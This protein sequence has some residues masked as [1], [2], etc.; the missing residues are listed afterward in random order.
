[1]IKAFLIDLDGTLVDTKLA[2]VAAYKEALHMLGF[3]SGE[4]ALE[5]WAGILPW[6]QMLSK[7]LPN[8]EITTL[9]KIA[10]LKRDL[11]SKYFHMVHV[12]EALVELIKYSK[13]KT[14]MAIVTS[15]SQ[16]SAIPLLSHLDLLNYFDEII[17]SEDCNLRK[18]HPEPYILAATRLNVSPDECL[19]FEDSDIGMKS[20]QA[21]GAKALRVNQNF[22]FNEFE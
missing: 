4:E 1:M 18:P 17:T 7:V 15:A 9:H 14:L 20:A 13:E 16:S 19:V 21:F 12:N 11:Y 10:L 2:N 5:K 8:A 3:F 6:D 22:P